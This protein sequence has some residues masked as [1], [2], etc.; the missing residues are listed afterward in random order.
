M[1]VLQ[2][3][4][5]VR[6]LG[7]KAIRRAMPRTDWPLR[8]VILM[9][10]RIDEEPFDPWGLS[11]SPVL[12]ERQMEWLATERTVLPLA[13]FAERHEAGTLPPKAAAVTFDDG[14]ASVATAAVPVLERLRLP[15]TI[16]IPADVIENR[17]AFWWDE[18]ASL[19]IGFSGTRLSLG[20]ETFELGS[21]EAGEWTWRPN[22]PPKTRRQQLFWRIWA[23]NRT[24]QI[25]DTDRLIEELRTQS[26]AESQRAPVMRPEQVR[27]INSPTVKIGSHALTHS[28]LPSL[29]S[30]R[31]R[32]EIRLSIGRCEALAG[33]TPATFAY[34]FGDYDDEARSIVAECGFAC[35]C[36]TEGRAVGPRASL[37][38]L[39]RVGVGN[40]TPEIFA[41]VLREL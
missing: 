35:A 10:H 8:P 1:N 14:Y 33:E 6:Q 7:R 41:R 9:Y 36:T 23:A 31:K 4:E 21:S 2:I 15:A 13:E 19:I 20:G 28:S 30:D 17:Q 32:R 5:R 34:P 22:A 27:S 40:W 18:L 24:R 16:F 11:V 38:R 37:S 29:P 39:P 26:S 25:E 12:F 3:A